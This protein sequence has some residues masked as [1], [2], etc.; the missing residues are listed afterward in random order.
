L[1]ISVV[2][3]PVTREGMLSSKLAEGFADSGDT[4]S[5]RAGAGQF[6]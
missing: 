2:F 6:D 3:I 4:I 1:P 5:E